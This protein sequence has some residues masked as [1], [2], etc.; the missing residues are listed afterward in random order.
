MS[1][2]AYMFWL[3][4]I[5]NLWVNSNETEGDA[6]DNDANG[7]IDDYKGY[8]F[9]D[10]AGTLVDDTGHGTHVAG[11]IAA[12]GNNDIGIIGVAPHAKI[13]PLRACSVAG[14]PVDLIVQALQ[15]ATNNG[16]DIIN[17]SFGGISE[18][19]LLN[20]AVTSVINQG[21]IVIAAAGNDS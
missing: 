8:N 5:A 3:D 12:T 17:C 13:M 10:A 16:A 4:I 11:I 6:I 1:Q 21:V 14:C 9:I 18:S 19:K 15:Y 7:Y 20:D 2:Y